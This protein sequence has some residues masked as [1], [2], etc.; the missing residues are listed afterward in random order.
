MN[1]A[2]TLYFKSNTNPLTIFVAAIDASYLKGKSMDEFQKCNRSYQVFPDGDSKEAGA[3]FV[4]D[5]TEV[6]AFAVQN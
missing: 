6:A 2:V 5:T 3:T 1:K 4:L